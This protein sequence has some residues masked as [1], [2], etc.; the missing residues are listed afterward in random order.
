VNLKLDILRGKF[1]YNNTITIP[2]YMIT[3]IPHWRI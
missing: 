1:D 2:I 3:T